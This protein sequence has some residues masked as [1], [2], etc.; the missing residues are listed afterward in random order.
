METKILS[1]Q[2]RDGNFVNYM[3]KPV[4]CSIKTIYAI[5]TCIGESFVF[6][7]IEINEDWLIKLGF[8]FLKIRAKYKIY[9][10]NDVRI[11]IGIPEFCTGIFISFYRGTKYINYIHELQ[12]AYYVINKRE[13][14]YV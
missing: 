2:L 8:N 1:K 13:L 11:S 9:E 7:P 6:Q 14:N 12:N 5:S 4:K 3:G 10:L